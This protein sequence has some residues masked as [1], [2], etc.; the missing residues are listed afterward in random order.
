MSTKL[1]EWLMGYI[2][3]LF[4][5]CG[6]RT[7]LFISKDKN[8]NFSIASVK[9]SAMS[10]FNNI[11]ETIYEVCVKV[12]SWAYVKTRIYYGSVRDGKWSDQKTMRKSPRLNLY[13][14]L[15]ER[16]TV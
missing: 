10:N 11:C 8:R 13:K 16:K 14:N 12:N 2:K 7:L 5:T 6:N 15:K 1:V 4:I 3:M 9:F